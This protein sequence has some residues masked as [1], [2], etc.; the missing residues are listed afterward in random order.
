MNK[1]MVVGIIQ[2]GEPDISIWKSKSSS[3]GVPDAWQ[4]EN[5]GGEGE[6]GPEILR[7]AWE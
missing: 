3:L 5:W 6:G 1:G 2:Q 4:V 7:E